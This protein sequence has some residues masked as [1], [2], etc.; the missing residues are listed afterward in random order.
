MVCQTYG[1]LSKDT[2][3]KVK[4]YMTQ[5]RWPRTWDKIGQGPIGKPKYYALLKNIARKWLPMMVCS[6][7]RLVPCPAIIREDSSCSRREQ[8]TLTSRNMEKL[9]DL[10]I[11]SPEWNVSIKSLPS[12][13]SELHGGGCTKSI[14]VRWDRGHQE[15]KDLSINLIKAHRDWGIIHRANTQVKALSWKEILC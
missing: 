12:E 2:T 10:G 14:S 4:L 5:L 1:C 9:T 15:N 3:V 6:T 13:L 8:I 7:H 11:L